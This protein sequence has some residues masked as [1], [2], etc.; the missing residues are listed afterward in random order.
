[1]TSS[2]KTTSSSISTKRRGPNKALQTHEGNLSRL[3]LSQKPRRF[4]FAAELG[5]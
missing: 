1:M 5:C 4:A 2:G 3:L